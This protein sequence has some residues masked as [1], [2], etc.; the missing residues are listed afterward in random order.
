MVCPKCSAEIPARFRFCGECGL[1]LRAEGQGSAETEK[2]PAADGDRR[3]LTVMF[4][5]LVGSTALSQRLDPEDLHRVLREYQRSCV[6]IVEALEGHVAQYLGDG[7]LIYFGYP[8]AHE[9]DARRAVQAGLGIVAAIDGVSRRLQPLEVDLAVR[10]G[11]HTGPVVTGEVGAGA[12]QERLALGPTPNV[13]ARIQSLAEPN[14]VALSQA[15]AQLIRG[16]FELQSLGVKALAGVPEPVQVWGALN[17][18]G[19]RRRQEADRR[20]LSVVGREKELGSLAA[21]FDAAQTRQGQLVL[22]S[23]EPG[24][25]KSRLVA[26]FREKVASRTAAVMELQCSSLGLHSALGPVA[27]LLS[28][29]SGFER[30]D[31]PDER[32]LKLEGILKAAG[33]ELSDAVPLVAELLGVPFA[34]RYRPLDWLPQRRKER[35]LDILVALVLKPAEQGPTLVLAED[36]HW[37]D[38]STMEFLERLVV[39]AADLPVLM[40][41]T[42]RPSFASPWTTRPGTTHLT[43]D[44]L[45]DPEA[46]AIVLGV[47]HGKALSPEV[48]R[49]VVLKTDGVPLFIEEVT[50][51]LIESGAVRERDGRYEASQSIDALPI[52]STLQDSLM[53]RLDR[54]ESGR[55]LAQLASVLGR[56]FSQEMLAAVSADDLETVQRDLDRLLR[57]EL[58]LRKANGHETL[59]TFKHALIQETA[60]KS[61]LKGTREKFHRQIAERLSERFPALAETRPELLALHWSEAHLPSQ[62]VDY[63][64]KAGRL[65]GGRSGNLEAIDHL[66]RGLAALETLPHDLAR[67]V[68]ELDLLTTLAPALIALKTYAAPEVERA[69]ERARKLSSAI[70]QTPQLFLSL[71]GLFTFYLVRGKLQTCLELGHQMLRLGESC[72]DQGIVLGARVALGTALF[73]RASFAEARA[74]LEDAIALDFPGRDRSFAFV[75]GQDVGLVGRLYCGLV[76]WFMGFPDQALKHSQSALAIARAMSHPFSLAFALHFDCLLRQFRGDRAT[77]REQAQELVK[78]CSEQGFVWWLVCG[79]A[80]GAWAQVPEGDASVLE[81]MRKNR[82]GLVAFGAVNGQTQFLCFEADSFLHFERLADA[83]VA[84]SEAFGW[85]R[86]AGETHCEPEVIRLEGELLLAESKDKGRVEAEKRFRRALELARQQGSR[87]MELRAACSLARLLEKSDRAVEARETLRPLVEWFTEGF[88]TSDL[89]EAKT[90]LDSLS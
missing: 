90:L 1:A 46:A 83:R 76:L 72:G 13:A 6:E 37:S 11:I 57:A 20:S 4:C 58:L 9:D 22:L 16:S 88:E 38:P 3:Q 8:S 53:A 85:V 33:V 68:R 12:R 64:L 66:T 24:I 77:V 75:T 78:I 36:L 52:P 32:L 43:I 71:W 82:Q 79:F 69:Y 14:M 30:S 59:L 47:T 28:H 65:A 50:K 15:T 39:R 44:R 21:A 84:L 81:V 51:V 5:D 31:T 35:L 18:S 61:L 45:G 27:D 89:S 70:G 19:A 87:G 2:K 41:M 40:L 63:W 56:E 73:Y 42:A 26:A 49:Q 25:G 29:R 34:G 55:A 86:D 62:A 10:V 7:I 48:L 60:Y 54:L 80:Q 74:Y 17:E 67:D 23:G